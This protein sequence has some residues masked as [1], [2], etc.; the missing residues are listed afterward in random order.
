[1]DLLVGSINA[2]S[3]TDKL[4]IEKCH[5]DEVESKPSEDQTKKQTNMY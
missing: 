4:Q 1:M 3:S 5:K 2:H